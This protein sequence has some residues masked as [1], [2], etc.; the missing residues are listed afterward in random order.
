VIKNNKPNK[1]RV[2]FPTLLI[3]LLLKEY[4]IQ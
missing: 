1:P 3:K 2:I 4:T